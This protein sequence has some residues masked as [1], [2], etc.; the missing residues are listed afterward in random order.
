VH[1]HTDLA[2]YTRTKGWE[3]CCTKGAAPFWTLLPV[4]LH[5]CVT[6]CW[7]RPPLGVFSLSAPKSGQVRTLYA[8][9]VTAKIRR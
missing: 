3:C 1:E 5:H 4:C 9:A 2:T 8:T 7:V 6:L